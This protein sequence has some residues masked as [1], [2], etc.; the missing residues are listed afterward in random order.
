LKVGT[1]ASEGD[2]VLNFMDKVNNM[3]S[4]ANQLLQNFGNLQNNPALKKIIEDRVG[5]KLGSQQLG[6]P[7][8]QGDK[9]TQAE[10]IY[11]QI[12]GALDGFSKQF[13]DM[14][15]TEASDFVKKNRHLALTTIKA[16]LGA[17]DEGK[18]T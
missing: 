6:L 5:K 9:D 14:T 13:G 4:L 3:M 1:V 8:P 10:A 17:K 7:L 2:W 18:P 12:V 16:N 11:E 15:I